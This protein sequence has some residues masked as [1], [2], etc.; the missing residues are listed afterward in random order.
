M[1]DQKSRASAMNEI[2]IQLIQIN[3]VKDLEKI[4]LIDPTRN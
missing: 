1:L 4:R 2:L 3:A